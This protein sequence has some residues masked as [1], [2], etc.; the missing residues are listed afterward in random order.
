MES[1]SPDDLPVTLKPAGGGGTDF[2]PPFAWVEEQEIRPAC[3]IYL[4]DLRSR[5]FP[6][7]PDYPVLWAATTGRTAPFGET[8]RLRPG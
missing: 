8:L 4:T 1:L 5:Y 7:P 3:L 6:R 2:R